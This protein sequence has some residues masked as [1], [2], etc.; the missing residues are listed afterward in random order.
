MNSLFELS[1]L[2]TISGRSSETA[3]TYI[4]QH[5]GFY[6]EKLFVSLQL[7]DGESSLVG[8]LRMLIQN[9][10]KYLPDLKAVSVRNLKTHQ[11]TRLTR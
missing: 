2:Q 7:Q 1:R 9:I 11:G 10:C 8:C 5:A 4:L 3:N 6:G